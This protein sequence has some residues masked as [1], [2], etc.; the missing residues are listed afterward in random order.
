[1]N[2]EENPLLAKVTVAWESRI[3]MLDILAKS[4]LVFSYPRR[5]ELPYP[6]VEHIPFA[7]FLVEILRPNLLVELGS[8]TGNSYNAFCQ[9]VELSGSHTKCFAVDTWQGDIHAGEYQSSIYD[10]LRS[11]QES[12]YP[13]F[14]TLL[15]M[16]FD[17]A[18]PKFADRSVDLL[19]IDGLHT[20]EAVKHD[21]DTWLPKVAPGG[22]ILMHDIAVREHDFGVWRLWEEIK[23]RFKTSEFTHGYGLGIVYIEGARERD[24]AELRALLA[25]HATQ[26]IFSTMGRAILRDQENIDLESGRNSVIEENDEIRR[27]AAHRRQMVNP[28]DKSRE[29]FGVPDVLFA[30]VSLDRGEGFEED[31]TYRQNILGADVEFSCVHDLPVEG[32]RGVFVM[33]VNAPSQLSAITVAVVAPDG[34]VVVLDGDSTEGMVAGPCGSFEST[35]DFPRIFF[36]GP[37]PR[38]IKELRIS[39][40]IESIGRDLTSRLQT[41]TYDLRSKLSQLTAKTEQLAAK[42]EQLE[43]SLGQVFSS[44]S[45]RC[46]APIRTVKSWLKPASSNTSVPSGDGSEVPKT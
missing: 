6:W 35:C 42:T 24:H 36:V 11:Y 13:Q 46:T 4:E 8:H 29:M 43:F 1:M 41:E 26:K 44:Y 34:D 45:W 9:A 14:S 39:Y 21:F 18:L 30:Q 20:Y 2:F 19:H 28:F 16:T 12:T 27:A 31:L 7:F 5:V 17:E 15:R 23:G 38:L 37:L 25:L 3:F 22:V 32:V 10:E 40:R 33:P